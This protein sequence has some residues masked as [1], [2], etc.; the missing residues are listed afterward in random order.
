MKK[1]VAVFFL[2][3]VGFVLALGYARANP[4]AFDPT[5]G[6][7]GI[8][9]TD[10]D[11]MDDTGNT[12]VLM[13]DG[14]LVAAGWVN[15][16]PGDFGVV[17]YLQDG[18]PDPSFGDGGRVVTAF[19]DDPELVDAAWG[20][21]ARPNGGVHVFGETCDADYVVCQFAMAAY[22]ADGSLDESFG[23][24]GLVTTSIPDAATALS[25]P[26]RNIL[27]ADGKVVAGGLILYENNDTDIVLLRYNSDGSLDETFG[28]GGISIIDFGEKV[29]FP[30]D[31]VALPGDKILIV[32]GVADEFEFVYFSE[33]A[34]MA[35]IN[36]DGSVDTGFGGGDGYLPWK[37][38]GGPLGFDR[39]LVTSASEMFIVGGNE[40]DCT[41]Q[42]FD[43]DGTADTTFGDNGWV[44]IDS[45]QF[46]LC[47]DAVMTVDGRIALVGVPGM[48]AE[49]DSRT[50]ILGRNY[51]PAAA[52]GAGSAESSPATRQEEDF[53]HIV[54][55]Y[56]ADGTPV[57]TFGDDGLARFTI[58]DGAGSYSNIAA[59]QDGKLLVVGDALE[60]EQLDM[61]IVRFLGDGPAAQVFMP[62]V[63]GGTATGE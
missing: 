50:A 17:R 57:T 33:E 28:N 7:E 11:G 42:R 25:W 18:N 1:A 63:Q 26:T 3:L 59:Q 27:Q 61:S 8:V 40:T 31:I 15:V 13:P 12:Q 58:N 54:G 56:N 14:K 20:I 38:D 55:L 53:D 29:Q 9:L 4:G 30:Q 39:A 10:F 21:N 48:P 2:L 36:S 44:I 5:W 52:R 6:E 60:G 47:L 49:S 46:D 51:N 34:F 35:R 62:V 16:Y 22:L 43:L 24:G 19:S 37:L 32:G 41:L 23:D 45:G